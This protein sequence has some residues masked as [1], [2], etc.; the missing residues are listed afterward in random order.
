M[1]MMN[2]TTLAT[3]L[4]VAMGL[5]LPDAAAII[6]LTDTKSTK[7]MIGV[8]NAASTSLGGAVILAA[9]ESGESTLAV[10]N[11]FATTPN[12][13][14]WDGDLSVLIPVPAD[15]TV[16]GSK[17][18]FVRVTLTGGAKFAAEPRLVCP[19]RA[20]A[21]DADVGKFLS[22]GA[23]A[24]VAH[25]ASAGTLP[26]SDI[27]KA[28]GILL[29]PTTPATSKTV[30]VFNF[31]SGVTTTKEGC[32]LT[33]NT[34]SNAAQGFTAAYS[35]TTRGDIGMSVEQG[36]IQGAV[37]TTSVVSGVFL[38]FKTAL[39]SLITASEAKGSISI[40]PVI[41]VKQASKKF[42]GGT[43]TQAILGGIKIVTG[44]VAHDKLR[45]SNVSGF[46]TLGGLAAALMTTAT[47]TIAG[48]PLAGLKTVGLYHV[49]NCGTQA[50]V[51]PVAPSS[52]S[53][54]NNVVLSNIPIASAILGL[55]VCATVDGT[56]TLN[57]GQL[58]AVLTGGGVDKMVPD[59]GGEGNLANVGIN[60]ARVRVLNVPST[61]NADQV[62]IRFYNASGQDTVVRGTLYGQDG[63]ILGSDNVMLFNPLKAYSVGVLDAAKLASLVGGGTPVPA[64]SG[65]AWLLV[66]AELDKDSFKVTGLVRTPQNVLVNLSTDASN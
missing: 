11:L 39:K 29:K 18:L 32:L 57:N 36:Y 45:L 53:G 61:T 41:D 30:A 14:W 33:F 16:V 58:T 37:I 35:I 55:N 52:T 42:E 62:F 59:L 1:K 46:S 12:M 15:Y 47:V 2:R 3:A 54:G 25:L 44:A 40:A 6:K 31:V 50:S 63:K 21:L 49:T 19:N 8:A 26:A 20:K 60:G 24:D 27:E 10:K 28:S 64:W 38:T 66:Q 48:N 9:E 7:P 51:S 17:T 56:T 43:P 34:A 4:A 13:K 65:R 22:I 23:G 5:Y